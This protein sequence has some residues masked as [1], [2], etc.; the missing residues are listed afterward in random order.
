MISYAAA[1][2]KPREW[3]VR[4]S[5]PPSTNWFF[6]TS[7]PDDYPH[8]KT[9]DTI[10]A[11]ED[12]M[13]HIEKLG[14]QYVS[15]VAVSNM[16]GYHLIREPHE[17][18]YLD[19][20]DEQSSDTRVI[21]KRSLAM[22]EHKLTTSTHVVWFEEQ[23][24]R[25][26]DRRSTQP[27]LPAF[28]DQLFPRE[29][30]LQDT[31]IG[32]SA[33]RLEYDLP[34]D[35]GVASVWQSGNTGE[36]VTIALVD[37]GMDFQHPDIASSYNPAAS[38]DLN[39]RSLLSLP[40]Y[41]RDNHGTRCAGQIIS[42]PNNTYCGVGLAYGAQIS[43]LR[44]ISENPT[45]YDEAAALGYAMDVN[46]IYSSSWGPADDAQTVEGPGTLTR[47]TLKE[48]V[49]SGR[50]GRGSIYVFASG[51]GGPNGDNC[52]FDGYANSIETITIGALS[53]DGTSP[54]YTESCA[55]QMA[56][57]F[58]GDGFSEIATTDISM[59]CASPPCCTSRHS[60]TSAAAPF[61]SAI[62]ALLISSRPELSW[63]DVQHIIVNAALKVDPNH[64][65]WIV[66]GAG[67][68]HSMVYGFGALRAE[69]IMNV[70]TNYS[71]VPGSSVRTY[72]NVDVNV[73]KMGGA[74]NVFLM[75]VSSIS[76]NLKG[77]NLLS[78]EHVEITLDIDSP[79]RSSLSYLLVSPLGTE[80]LLATGRAKDTS[81]LGLHG[82]T[83]MS[84][85]FW[86]EPLFGPWKLIV[87]DS[88]TSGDPAKLKSIATTWHGTAC[89]THESKGGKCEW[90]IVQEQLNMEK[91]RLVTFIFM[92]V[93]VF[94]VI[95]LCG[96]W[97]WVQRRQPNKY[98]S[99]KRG[100]ALLLSTESLELS[101]SNASRELFE[102][103]ATTPGPA[104]ASPY[105]YVPKRE[106]V[107]GTLSAIPM[108][109]I[110]FVQP[111]TPM[112]YID[113]SARFVDRRFPDQADSPSLSRASSR[114]NLLLPD[115]STPV[116]NL[117]VLDTTALAS[118]GV[119][120]GQLPSP[121]PLTNSNF[122]RSM[123]SLIQGSLRSSLS[124]DTFKRSS[125]TSDLLA[126][127]VSSPK[128]PKSKAKFL[129]SLKKKP[130]RFG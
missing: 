42:K 104:S 66:N 59:N 21:R 102:V 8:H 128:S 76:A 22:N 126:A 123:K 16:Q 9:D 121:S 38:Y 6:E 13:K 30:F 51:N 105:A 124:V 37:D 74:P 10:H 119:D 28:N 19:G 71:Q 115:I 97:L 63:R 69:Q 52:A 57:A 58:S 45:D 118:L 83:F 117:P 101:Q 82:W 20:E 64:P 35:F 78:L 67:Y 108:S 94:F 75:T 73:L 100:H 60:G 29:W 70:S 122:S 93:L 120:V 43:G 95:I 87:I 110:E 15:Q 17:T 62:I 33:P 18:I 90:Q 89:Q 103:I 46:D 31:H 127:T 81:N 65:S 14:F 84:V 11:V 99:K 49:R 23:V 4:L 96:L 44:V 116:N 3:V 5:T 72:S 114:R 129:A 111:K 130:S 61:A 34:M 1:D 7:K 125:S 32:S 86:G 36:S 107:L 91:S 112:E 109:P 47:L 80:S 50:Q 26:R 92:S 88:R 85:Q 98:H 68:H 41:T 24:P 106:Q 56:V 25:V 48:G 27:S 53:I 12:A 54:Y 55:S 77:A 2:D 39:T 79:T 40:K 113:K